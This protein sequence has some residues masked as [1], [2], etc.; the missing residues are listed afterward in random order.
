M[1]QSII[2]R[3]F[4]TRNVV[5]AAALLTLIV[6]LFAALYAVARETSVLL[7][8][9]REGATRETQSITYPVAALPGRAPLARGGGLPR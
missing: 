9:S 6:V 1:S 5:E 7:S 4:V 3:R 8:L 2:Q